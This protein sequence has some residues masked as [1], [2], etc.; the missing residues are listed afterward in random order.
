ML[1]IA[2]RAAVRAHWLE[3]D[4]AEATARMNATFHQNV[5]DDKYAT[6]FVGRMDLATS[7]LE[8]VNAG[9]NPPLVVRADGRAET[10]TE[11]G[12]MLGAF[13]Q[14]AYGTSQTALSPGD[15]LLIFSD[16][17]SDAWPIPPLAERALTDVVRQMPGADA[18]TLQQEIL[19]AATRAA[20]HPPTDDR[21]LIVVR[22]T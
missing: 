13:P 5:P 17:I 21:T 9:H 6:F 22:R 20:G 1:M 14:A 15:V 16:G 18:A 4:L 11:G 19:V 10:L 2:L 3:P 12:T 7:T 8:F